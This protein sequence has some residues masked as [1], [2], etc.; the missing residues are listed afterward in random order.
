MS[1]GHIVSNIFFDTCGWAWSQSNANSHFESR[2]YQ[3]SLKNISTTRGNWHKRSASLSD[4]ISR[5]RSHNNPSKSRFNEAVNLV[6]GFTSR[7]RCDVPNSSSILSIS[8]CCTICIKVLVAGLS[9]VLRVAG[10]SAYNGCM[11]KGCGQTTCPLDHEGMRT[12]CRLLASRFSNFRLHCTIPHFTYTT[13]RCFYKNGIRTPKNIH[14]ARQGIQSSH[15]SEYCGTS[16][17]RF[18]L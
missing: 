8:G 11:E 2:W 12:G 17:G 4:R 15:A 16:A 9:A 18:R 6:S 7:W 14:A 1:I 10:L 5:D 3:D 13:L